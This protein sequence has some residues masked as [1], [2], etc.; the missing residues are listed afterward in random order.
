M[1][2]VINT[3]YAATTAANNLAHS[4]ELLQKS[5]NRLSSGSKIVNPSDDAGGL[6]VSMKLSAAAR[7]QGAVS[8]NI[9][10]AVSMLQTQDGVLAVTGKIL[11]RMSE[12]KVLN[13]DITKS[14]SD[15]ANYQSEFSALQTQITANGAEKFNGVSLF[16]TTTVSVAA[17]E[18]GNTA[19]GIQGTN[20][21]GTAGPVAW[22]NISNDI[23]PGSNWTSSN[24]SISN[25]AGYTRF[26][27][28]G[29][30]TTTQS[31]I[32][33]PYTISFTLNSVGGSPGTAT[34]TGGG[35]GTLDLAALTSDG[36]DH[37]VSISVDAAGTASW[38]FQNGAQ[39][40]TIAN[41]GSVSGGAIVF[42]QT[43]S[44]S[45]D[46][47]VG[48][49][50]TL[51]STAGGGASNNVGGVAGASSLTSVNLS[52]ITG[53][54][55]DLA[56][57]RAQ[58]GASQSRFQFATELL[59]VNKANLEAANSRITDVDVA[60]ESTALARYN[61]LVQAG[62]SMLAQANQSSQLA[63]KLLQ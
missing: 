28:D 17:T 48:D 46:M 29:T 24:P 54:I 19:V 59:T 58:N 35:G 62:T 26:H 30:L 45:V 40:G 16:G 63:L 41:F 25:I 10:N 1:S 12:L 42:S 61:V 53:A 18:D 8:T 51:T 60:Q 11:N 38:S 21:L 52:T 55:S 23:A 44:G 32:S 6:A 13:S 33:G 9:A 47:H 37:P 50:F 7:R 36:S 43:G 5:L 14:S 20:L 56:T 3:N 15:R 57:Y 34:I 2:V 39:T 22:S 4:N 49:D 31:N 27:G